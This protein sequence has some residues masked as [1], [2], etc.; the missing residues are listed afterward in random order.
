MNRPPLD[1]ITVLDISTILAA[2]LISSLLGEFG[3][4][5]IKIEQP[6]VGDPTRGYPPLRDG[7]SPA[8]ER[9]G[10]GKKSIGID[11][12]NPEAAGLVLELVKDA[13]I[14]VSNFRPATLARFGLDFDDLRTVNDRIVL[15]HLTAY[16]RTGPYSE[17]PGFA[18][19]VEAFSGLT[20][21]TGF[22]D[23]PPMF[24]GYAIAD[25]VSGMYGAFAAM[26]ALR[27]R[28]T[29]GEAQLVDLGLYEP[30]LRMMEDFLPVYGALGA[31][32]GRK[33]NENP[34]IAP[35]G[36]F[37]TG[38]K[39]WIV[40][41]ASTDQM[42]S[43]LRR[44]MGRED[45]VGLDR[46]ADRVAHRDVVDNAVTDY[47]RSRDLEPLLE[48]LHAAGIVAGPVN[49]AEDIVTDPHIR[50]RGSVLEVQDRHGRPSYIPSPAGRFSGF[51][52]D[53][54]GPAPSI[55]QDTE[56]IL[57]ERLHVDPETIRSLRD[58]NVIS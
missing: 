46:M 34:A 2:P 56:S 40:I 20:H 17:R 21:R 26:T 41:P 33:G 22:P 9:F 1:G 12:H 48:D 36:I 53:P 55:G 6:G 57:R 4:E 54:G 32:A 16:G 27:Q 8:W 51:E 24:S 35:N 14:V 3:A 5:V 11:L 47:V 15:V 52:V 42:W 30:M 23:G 29:T 58:G 49:T 13:D 19:V 18:R 10:R 38:D 43:R 31:V 28:D 39:R 7:E 50:E 37:R 45:L 25:G 44:L